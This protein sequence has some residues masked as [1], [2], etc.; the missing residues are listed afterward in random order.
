MITYLLVAVSLSMDAFAVSVSSG[1][2]IPHLRLRDA[3]RASFAFGLFQFLMPLLGW[4]LGD[5]LRAR[6]EGF[7]HWVAFALLAF[8]GGKMIIE[9]LTAKNP[10]ACDDE[11]SVPQG[12][13]NPWTLLALSI[14]TSIDALAIGI[15]YSVL[16]SPIVLPATII[17][18]VTFVLCLLGTEFGKRL[19]AAFER[20]AEVIGGLILIGIGANLVIQHFLRA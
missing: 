2:C 12:I 16:R 11:E 1:I 4:F 18:S 7:S 17:G 9:T 20:W 19:G 15:S 8:V 5:M 13:L 3:L 6:V 14:A 10:A